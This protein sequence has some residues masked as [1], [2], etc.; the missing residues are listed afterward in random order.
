V[1]TLDLLLANGWQIE[2]SRVVRR[3]GQCTVSLCLY[4]NRY[5]TTCVHGTGTTIPGALFNASDLAMKW[6]RQQ[7]RS[8]PVF[9]NFPACREWLEPDVAATC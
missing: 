7:P 6:I 5:R 4:L 9:V 8:H 1:E 3:H 2:P